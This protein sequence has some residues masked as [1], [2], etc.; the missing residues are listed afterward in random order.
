[1]ATDKY[2]LSYVDCFIRNIPMVDCYIK[3]YPLPLHLSYLPIPPL[4]VVYYIA[5]L[6]HRICHHIPLLHICWL[7]IHSSWYAHASPHILFCSASLSHQVWWQSLRPSIPRLQFNWCI[8][9][10][11]SHMNCNIQKLV[12]YLL[13]A[14]IEVDCR[15]ESSSHLYLPG[16]RLHD[17]MV[18]VKANHQ[19]TDIFHPLIL[20]V[21]NPYSPCPCRLHDIQ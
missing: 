18:H 9:C 11:Q 16:A 12:V 8:L 2:L 3:L 15:V 10:P 1:M 4:I 14:F 13:R 21:Y 7:L 19:S 5:I 20:V 6:R 17:M